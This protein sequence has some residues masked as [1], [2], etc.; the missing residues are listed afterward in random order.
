MV[1]VFIMAKANIFAVVQKDIQDKTVKVI[2]SQFYFFLFFFYLKHFLVK[3]QCKIENPCKH[4]GICVELSESRYH[5][6][7]PNIWRG[8]HCEG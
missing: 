6:D 1:L 4:G 5:C 8:E 2:I 7:C 3:S